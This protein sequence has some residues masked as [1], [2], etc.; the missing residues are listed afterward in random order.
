[1]TRAPGPDAD[2]QVSGDQSERDGTEAAQRS[3][4]RVARLLTPLR[5]TKA[6]RIGVRVGIGLLGFVVVAG[7]LVLVPLPG[8]G[9]LI[10]FAGLAIWSLEFDRAARLHVW[11]RR[12][13][14][15]W[16][17][18]MGRQGW[19][20]RIAVGLATAVFVAAVVCLSLY[21]SFGPDVFDRLRGLF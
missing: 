19:P 14:S 10:V 2:S 13:F 16:T 15:R 3:P 4:G 9:W 20:V 18:W 7:G 12:Q 21:A 6:G 8:P 1:V 17:R 5:A 11:G